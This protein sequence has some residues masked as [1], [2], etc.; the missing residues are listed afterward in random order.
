MSNKYKLLSEIIMGKYDTINEINIKK[1]IKTTFSDLEEINVTLKNIKDV[2]MLYKKK[3]I[4]IEKL[5]DWG[6]LVWFNEIFVYKKE[7]ESKISKSLYFIE[8]LDEFED[9]DFLL[10]QIDKILI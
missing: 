2:V 5:I 6:N 4:S 3:Y 10:K 1:L 7:E 8:Q 9:K